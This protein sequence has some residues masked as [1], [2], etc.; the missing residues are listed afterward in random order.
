MRPDQWLGVPRMTAPRLDLR[1]LAY[2]AAAA[3]ILLIALAFVRAAPDHTITAP[4]S[5]VT[6]D[7]PRL[8][9]VI[10]V[11][12]RAE[13]ATQPSA[14]PRVSMELDLP[15]AATAVRHGGAERGG[16]EHHVAGYQDA[17]TGL[18]Q[19]IGTLA[20]HADIGG[21]MA[22][23][24]TEALA[25]GPYVPLDGSVCSARC[26]GGAVKKRDCILG[27]HKDEHGKCVPDRP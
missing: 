17:M 7:A 8:A 24:A 23:I 20:G 22:S 18:D 25:N 5:V 1:P 4:L 11:P 13:P 6:P 16:G 27:E 15:G 2:I 3:V 26:F 12:S 19:A 10:H 14:A 9:T 21:G